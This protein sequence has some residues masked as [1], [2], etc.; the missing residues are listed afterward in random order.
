MDYIKK[1]SRTGEGYSLPAHTVYDMLWAWSEG[2]LTY[3]EV[4]RMMDLD[5]FRTVLP[6]GEERYTLHQVALENSVPPP[7]WMILNLG[8]HTTP[9]DEP[10]EAVAA[11]RAGLV[12]FLEDD[13]SPERRRYA[14][15]ERGAIL[16]SM[17]RRRRTV[18]PARAFAEGFID[19][20]EALARSGLTLP[21]LVGLLAD[22][23]LPIPGEGEL[24][25]YHDDNDRDFAEATARAARHDWRGPTS[26]RDENLEEPRTVYDLLAS[27]SV[28]VRT[29]VEVCRRLGITPDELRATAEVAKLPPP[30]SRGVVPTTYRKP[31]PPVSEPTPIRV[32]HA[33]GII[34][35]L[36]PDG[37]GGFKRRDGKGR[38]PI[39]RGGFKP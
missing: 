35:H 7:D 5:D 32:G 20:D 18:D 11:F 10:A 21:E 33:T 25:F 34:R 17:E 22:E 9:W 30:A 37:S 38:P 8:F 3:A 2:H 12:P 29:G 39:N 1:T 6:D 4:V 28:G 16:A 31:E 15:I 24:A 26:G 13:A 14:E 27:W 19:R 23:E 36:E